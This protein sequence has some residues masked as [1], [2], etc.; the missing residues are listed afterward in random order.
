M[1]ASSAC[2]ILHQS[3]DSVSAHKFCS[4][5]NN[6]INAISSLIPS[7]G[8][9]PRFVCTNPCSV[10][11]SSLIHPYSEG[12][13]GCYEQRQQTHPSL[14]IGPSQ[15][16]SANKAP[17]RLVY[18]LFSLRSHLHTYVFVSVYAK[19]KE[20]TSLQ[21]WDMLLLEVPLHASL[22]HA[23]MMCCS[24]LFTT[25]PPPL[26]CFGSVSRHDPVCTDCSS[27]TLVPDR[28]WKIQTSL[29]HP[30]YMAPLKLNLTSVVI[31]VFWIY[32]N[33]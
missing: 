22:M 16:F 14:V 23:E 2:T 29:Y 24:H 6:F 4:K 10:R 7:S 19:M 9:S 20:V 15:C 25:V 30:P 12:F 18:A 21:V 27:Y 32:G 31:F 1:G 13:L 28:D 8:S 3:T 5:Q 26:Q 11:L 17:H 33:K